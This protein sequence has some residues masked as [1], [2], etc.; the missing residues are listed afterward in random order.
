MAR[1]G[2]LGAPRPSLLMG[3]ACEQMPRSA[4]APEGV[5]AG[6]KRGKVG[7]DPRIRNGPEHVAVRGRHPSQRVI[8]KPL[9]RRVEADVPN[10]A[11]QLG[12]VLHRTGHRDF[13]DPQS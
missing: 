7:V 4:A 10:E 1:S 3:E 13:R 12:R 5:G 11:E 8:D 9:A 2:K 6:S